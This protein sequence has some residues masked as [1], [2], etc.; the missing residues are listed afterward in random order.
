MKSYEIMTITNVNIGEE[1]SRNL[2]NEVKD[3]ISQNKG[4]VF[5][6]NFWGKRKFA[7]PIKNQTE[8]YYDVINFEMPEDLMPQFKNKLNLIDNLLRYLVTSA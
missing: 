4:K 3:L 5:D 7:Y 6:S 8:G 1:G 2:S